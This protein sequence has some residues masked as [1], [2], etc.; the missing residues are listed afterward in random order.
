MSRLATSQKS[1]PARKKRKHQSEHKSERSSQRAKGTRVQ[2]S[3]VQTGCNVFHRVPRAPSP[4]GV[5]NCSR[6]LRRISAKNEK[7]D[8]EPCVEVKRM[9]VCWNS[10]VPQT[11][12]HKSCHDKKSARV[13]E[14]NNVT[15]TLLK[16][17]KRA[18]AAVNT[19]RETKLFRRGQHCAVERE[20]PLGSVN[21][22]LIHTRHRPMQ[23]AEA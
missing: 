6:R 12:N 11:R 5:A 9:N 2:R 1:P 20:E 17:D 14:H 3:R 13:N 15:C 8:E 16:V 22:P 19:G 4:V 7:H 23:R 10:T 18:G 21:R